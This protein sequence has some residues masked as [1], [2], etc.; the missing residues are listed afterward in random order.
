M[1]AGIRG[2]QAVQGVRI[3]MIHGKTVAPLRRILKTPL[4]QNG[5]V[6]EPCYYAVDP[7]WHLL[8]GVLVEILAY[9]D[10]HQ[11]HDRYDLASE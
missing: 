7:G 4:Q 10:D 1:T 11:S 3:E 6:T 9:Q 8:R 5:W 2:A